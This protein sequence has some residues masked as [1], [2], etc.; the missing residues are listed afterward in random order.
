MKERKVSIFNILKFCNVGNGG[1]KKC[2]TVEN[3]S[4]IAIESKPDFKSFN[5]DFVAD[6]E[7]GQEVIFN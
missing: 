2:V 4:T 1:H 7:V 3:Q 6:E 5:F